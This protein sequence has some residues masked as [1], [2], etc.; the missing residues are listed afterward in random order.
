MAQNE[1]ILY[2]RLL[3]PRMVGCSI[4]FTKYV[5]EWVSGLRAITYKPKRW[6]HNFWATLYE[7]LVL[8]HCYLQ[9]FSSPM[10]FVAKSMDYVSF[11]M[12]Y[13]KMY[14]RLNSNRVDGYYF[15]NGVISHLIALNIHWGNSSY[16]TIVGGESSYYGDI[17]HITYS[18]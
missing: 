12:L 13:K 3:D 1:L 18:Y 5:S 2:F 9:S 17:C 7:I 11:N 15:I 4:M 8:L 14:G 16:R 10:T 6:C